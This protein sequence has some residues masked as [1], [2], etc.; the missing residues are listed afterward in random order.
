VTGRQVG[1]RL[2]GGRVEVD[3]DGAVAGARLAGGAV[4]QE[5]GVL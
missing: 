4:A 5:A 2:P 3:L 1:Q